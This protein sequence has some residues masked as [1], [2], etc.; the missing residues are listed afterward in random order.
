MASKQLQLAA[1]FIPRITDPTVHILLP[2]YSKPKQNMVTYNHCPTQDSCCILYVGV[3]DNQ[4]TI[5][6]FLTVQSF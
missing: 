4:I 1:V 5:L 3:S 2:G 6:W